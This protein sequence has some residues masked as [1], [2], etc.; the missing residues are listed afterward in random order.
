MLTSLARSAAPGAID[1]AEEEGDDGGEEGGA[2]GEEGGAGE[3][4][5]AKAKAPKRSRPQHATVEAAENHTTK[6]L[7]AAVAVDP[8]F[9]K[10]GAQFD[11]GGAKGLLMH[12]LCVHRGC[13]VVFDSDEA[14]RAPGYLPVGPPDAQP[15]AR[16]HCRSRTTLPGRR[17][18]TPV[19]C[20]P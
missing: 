1:E 17:T 8:L 12:N 18:P 3:G 19:R 13:D 4:K 9:A 6:G 5:A 2:G 14:R 11:E 15:P 20:P 16:A 7:E 10:T